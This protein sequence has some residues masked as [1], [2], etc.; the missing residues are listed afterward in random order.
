MRLDSWLHAVRLYK[1]R[2]LATEA[3]RG[4]HVKIDGVSPKPAHAVK[5]G[6][7]VQARTGHLVLTYEVL[8]FPKSRISA[9]LVPQYAA[10]RTP[11]EIYERERERVAMLKANPLPF[12]GGRPTGKQRRVL[13]EFRERNAD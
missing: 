12:R 7:L 9:S 8:G 10:N 11:E 4:G 3:V 1:T 2:S 6:D 5:V 13:D